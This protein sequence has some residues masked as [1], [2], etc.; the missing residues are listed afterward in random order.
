MGQGG[1][2]PEL[3][4]RVRNGPWAVLSGDA[5]RAAAKRRE[6]TSPGSRVL[7]WPVTGGAAALRRGK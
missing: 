6:R 7:A 2:H 5:L 4:R 3:L 1:A